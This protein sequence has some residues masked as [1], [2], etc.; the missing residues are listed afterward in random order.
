MLLVA[1]TAAQAHP[2]GTL[3]VDA[4]SQLALGP[5]RVIMRYHLFLPEASAYGQLKLM[6]RNGDGVYSDAEKQAYMAAAA[7]KVLANIKLRLNG[8]PLQ[9]KMLSSAAE[10]NSGM[11][12]LSTLK[13]EY[14]FEAPTVGVPLE[15]SGN[16]LTFSDTNFTGTPGWKEIQA[17]GEGD[18]LVTS[19]PPHPSSP[20]EALQ[21]DADIVFSP[22]GGLAAA[23]KPTAAAARPNLPS[24]EAAQKLVGLLSGGITVKMLVIGL[25]V[26]FCLGA[27]HGF[28]PGHGKTIVGAYLV[29]SRGTIGQAVFLGAVVT[30]TH[31][32]SVI[33]LG[34]VS[35]LLFQYVMP[36]RLYPWLGFASGALIAVMGLV[37][38][39]NKRREE[40]QGAVPHVHDH[41]DHEHEHVHEESLELAGVGTHSHSHSHSHSQGG[42]HHHGNRHNHDHGHGRS[43]DHDH[44]HD[45]GHSHAHDHPHDHGH[46]HDHD[47]PHDHGHS[48][49]HDQPHDHGHSHDHDHPHDHGHSHD[50]DHPHDHGHSHD[51]DHPHDHGHSP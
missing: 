31:T 11:G 50:H 6:D 51:H 2:F 33:L 19:A 47:H 27:L 26:A 9:L 49:D 23:T 1:V 40:A 13:M 25:A 35:M 41:E 3:R 42:G 21:T 7:P 22:H 29:G 38:I 18:F 20:I 43:H 46:S 36:E 28:T 10:I 17:Q 15:P 34:L 44:P 16:H 5:D 14:V 12:G 4:T 37:L 30:F 32:I 8:H 45:H 24:T 48:Q 39:A